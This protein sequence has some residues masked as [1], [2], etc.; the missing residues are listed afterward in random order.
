LIHEK[1]E[2]A[3]PLW[4]LFVFFVVTLTPLRGLKGNA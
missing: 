3:A 4:C 1:R 2:A